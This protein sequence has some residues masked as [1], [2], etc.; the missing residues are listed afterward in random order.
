M[1]IVMCWGNVTNPKLFKCM[2]NFFLNNACLLTITF[3][4]ISVIKT[5]S[6]GEKNNTSYFS[7]ILVMV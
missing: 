2:F 7:D 5:T 1:T 6:G 4:L 3:I